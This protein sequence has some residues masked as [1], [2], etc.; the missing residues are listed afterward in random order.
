MRG[1]AWWLQDAIMWVT[2]DSCGSWRA[3]DNPW[4]FLQLEEQ[5]NFFCH[6]LPGRTCD[7]PCEWDPDGLRGDAGGDDAGE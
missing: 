2:C 4:T 5:A 3:V 1:A 6:Q 7:Q